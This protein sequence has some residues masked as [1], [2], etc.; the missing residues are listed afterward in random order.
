MTYLAAL[1]ERVWLL[2]LVGAHAEVL[3][4]L[5]GVL[6]A[7]KKDGVGTSGLL[8]GKLIQSEA[9]AAGSVDAGTGG[10]G[11]AQGGD[12]HLGDLGQA[13]IIGDGA[14]DD[15]GL[16]LG[17]VVKVGGD[18][19]DGHRG[20]VHPGHKETAQDDLVEGGVGAAWQGL[21]SKDSTMSP[22]G[23]N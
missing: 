5:T 14:D 3:E 18:A 4:C 17:L 11:E 8:E 10:G 13:D 7:T 21:V 6:G 2:V 15:D 20:A 9:R 19:G 1:G 12:L 22:S 23:F 16:L